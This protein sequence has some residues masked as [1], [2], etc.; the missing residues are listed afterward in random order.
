MKD[1]VVNAI[2]N[3]VIIGGL[4][5]TIVLFVNFGKVPLKYNCE[6]CGEQFDTRHSVLNEMCN[7]CFGWN[8][9]K[10]SLTENGIQVNFS[11]G[12][13]YFFQGKN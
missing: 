11:N 9:H 10:A 4:A 12:E 3:M 6:F 1:R 8:E 5:L 7:I 13:G 2:L